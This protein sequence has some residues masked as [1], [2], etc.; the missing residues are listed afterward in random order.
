MSCAQVG[1]L[2][3]AALVVTCCLSLSVSSQTH[4]GITNRPSRAHHLQSVHSSD[5]SVAVSPGAWSQLG[6][7]IP[8]A[9]DNYY[10]IGDSVA[11]DGGTVVVSSLPIFNHENAAAYVFT[12]PAGGWSNL[13]S[14]AS[15]V[16]PANAGLFSS[17]A[18]QGDTIVVG[19]ADDTYGPGTAYVFVRPA[20]GWTNML[21]TAT[22]SASDSM[23]GDDFGVVAAIDGN[24]IVVGASGNNNYIGAAYVYTKPAGGWTDATETAK[25]TSTDGQADDFMGEA[26]SVSGN[27]IVAGAVQKDP[28]SGKSYIYVEPTSGWASM[29][30]TAEL[31]SPGSYDGF[32]ASVSLDGNTLLIGARDIYTGSGIAYLY[33]RPANGWHSTPPMAELA[34]AD[35]AYYFGF[36]VI[37]RGKTAVIGASLRSRGPNIEEGGVYIFQE[38]NG[39]WKNSK[40]STVLTATDARHF[41]WFGTGVSLSGNMLAVGGTGVGNGSA[42]VFGLP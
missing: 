36:P 23:S 34:S 2:K 17:V 35:N 11:I 41:S 33:S 8:I 31:I 40:S 29:T 14:V 12:E 13:H 10:A 25:L 21:P 20:G 37:L 22:L 24:T 5:P 28:A 18:I 16:V 38:P 19:D 7:L 1:Y 4:P 42:Y 6:Q 3:I 32:G 30:Q 27:T 15:L 26:V 9:S 39:G